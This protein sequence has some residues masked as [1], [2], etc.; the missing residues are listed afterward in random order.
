[1]TMDVNDLI[2]NE[3]SVEEVI[4][5]RKRLPSVKL[6]KADVWW[7]KLLAAGGFPQHRIAA[8]FDVNQG[9]ISEIAS[10]FKTER[11]FED[12]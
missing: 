7:I 2:G 5:R 4:A 6:V 12:G 1:M 8:L 9:R 10:G 11:N 3:L